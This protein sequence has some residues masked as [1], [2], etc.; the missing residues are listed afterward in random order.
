[1]PSQGRV[2]W[3]MGMPTICGAALDRSFVWDAVSAW[4]RGNALWTQCK[5]TIL[6]QASLCYESEP[7]SWDIGR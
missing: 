7:L 3:K 5:V 2:R 1:M 4:A 6:F